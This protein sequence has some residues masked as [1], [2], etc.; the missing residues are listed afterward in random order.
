MIKTDSA[1]KADEAIFETRYTGEFRDDQL[2]GF[3]IYE[4]GDGRRYEV[5]KGTD[6]N[7]GSRVLFFL[8]DLSTLIF[9]INFLKVSF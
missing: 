9:K 8:S 6:T 2:H 3:G 5:G 4:F 7:Q 1:D